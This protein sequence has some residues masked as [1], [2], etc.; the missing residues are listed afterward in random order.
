[1]FAVQGFLFRGRRFP[2]QAALEVSGVVSSGL[3]FTM[4]R[5]FKAMLTP[6]GASGM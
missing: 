2:F 4:V 6:V 3:G 5:W 1:M